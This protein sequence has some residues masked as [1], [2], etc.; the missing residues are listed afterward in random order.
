MAYSSKLRHEY[1][2]STEIR[3]L[4]QHPETGPP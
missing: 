2:L 1:I 3:E 4:V